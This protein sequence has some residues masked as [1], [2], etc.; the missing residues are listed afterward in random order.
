MLVRL[1][2]PLDIVARE[3]RLLERL[4]LLTEGEPLLV[5]FYCADMWDRSQDGARITVADLDTLKPGFSSYF[6]RWLKH[7]EQ[8]WKHEGAGV[9]S[10]KVDRV[11]LIL[12]H[13]L[14]RLSEGDLLALMTEMHGDPGLAFADRLLRPLRRFVMGDGK[15]NTGFVLSHPKIGDYL[16]AER[17]HAHDK[18]VLRAFA[19]WGRKWPGSRP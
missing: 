5:R 19:S 4:A 1:G 13:A 6:E 2:A 16:R 7:Q 17:F 9:D 18:V 3:P 15:R 10:D 8:L 11:L 14:G 12:A